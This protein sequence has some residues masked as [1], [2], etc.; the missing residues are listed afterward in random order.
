MWWDN[1]VA[2]IVV[3]GEWREN[4]RMSKTFFYKLCKELRPFTERQSTNTISPVEVER[5]VAVTLY[6]LSDEGR[7]RETA[8]AFG[9]SRSCV[10]LT[11]QRVARA[12]TCIYSKLL[13]LLDSGL[14]KHNNGC[15]VCCLAVDENGAK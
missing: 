14:I 10:S 2:D 15:C 1:F 11:V 9:L 4:F 7:L 13:K 6:H 12:V 3:P 5:Q 8:N